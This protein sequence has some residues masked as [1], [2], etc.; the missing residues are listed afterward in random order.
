MFLL[1]LF[2][3][4]VFTRDISGHRALLPSQDGVSFVCGT[5]IC[6]TDLG[7]TWYEIGGLPEVSER[8]GRL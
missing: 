1:I 5:D 6:G 3:T 8:V 4:C 2:G 7:P